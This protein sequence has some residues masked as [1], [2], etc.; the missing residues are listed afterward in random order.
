MVDQGETRGLQAPVAGH[1][2][3]IA[4][5][6]ESGVTDAVLVTWAA[7]TKYHT[8]R[9]LNNTGFLRALEAGSPS[10]GCQHSWFLEAPLL[11]LGVVPAC[12][13]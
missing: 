5:P 4:V 3:S 6:L 9:D 8:Q 2:Y 7:I 12:S 13:L 1:L 11:R 10:S